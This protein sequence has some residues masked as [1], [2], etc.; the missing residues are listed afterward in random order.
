MSDEPA[1]QIIACSC[2]QKMK[3]PGNAAGKT[4]KCVKCG[5]HILVPGTPA[6]AP[7]S[8]APAGDEP[9]A[10]EPVGQLLVQA[11]CI[12]PLQLDEALGVQRRDGGK[13]FEILIRLGYLDKAR[14]H[15]VLSK[16]PGMAA[17]DLSRVAIDRDLAQ[18]VPREM[19]LG[20]LVLPIDKLG[21]L[22]TV[23][24]ACPLDVATIAEIE[25]L[26][27]QKVKAMLCRY[28]DIQTAVQKQ[29]PDPN[30]A[31]G[32]LH[33]FQLPAGYDTGNKEDVSEKLGRM[34]EIHY[35]ADVLDRVA[36]LLK[37]PATGLGIVLETVMHDPAFSAAILR[38]AN[39]AVFGMA[40]QV[41]SLT[42]ALTLLG[43]DGLASLAARCKK[44]NVAPQQNLGPLY[45]RAVAAANNAA[46][47]ARATGRVGHEI[48][49]T[50]GLLHGIGSFA[51]SAASP[52]R[53]GKVNTGLEVAQLAAAEKQAFSLGHAE[54]ALVLLKRWRY[55]ES[56][57]LA[58]GHYLAPEGAQK[59]AALAAIVLASAGGSLEAAAEAAG[60]KPDA[61]ARGQREEEKLWD[62]LRTTRY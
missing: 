16:Q 3:V 20:Q 59:H 9:P 13:T 8:P 2:G 42:L 25:R 30:T 10:L 56:L 47:I 48:A 23:A 5:E 44:I 28:D 32:E 7:A 29:Y 53:H 17:L 31:P 4:Y 46:V 6:A 52:Q 26:T 57:Q 54:A 14:L 49:M 39:S 45:E 18:L 55:P 50:A 21:K 37:D 40:G 62:M 58:L 22:L 43:R 34:E 35:R 19:A 1:P 27:G 24:M 33:T 61:I 15:E 41:D 36:T 38:T 12:T 11:G 60:A 51:M